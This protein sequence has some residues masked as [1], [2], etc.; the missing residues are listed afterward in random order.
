MD[1]HGKSV[2]QFAQ[3]IGILPTR[4]VSA[5]TPI[6]INFQWFSGRAILS[7]CII[8]FG[9]L[10]GCFEFFTVAQQKI[11]ARSMGEMNFALDVNPTYQYFFFF[12]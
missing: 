4:G 10:L 6:G 9:V 1:N 3:L 12:S 7:G 8:F 2:F 11:S 5:Y